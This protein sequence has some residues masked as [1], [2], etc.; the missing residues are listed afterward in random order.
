MMVGV[1]KLKPPAYAVLAEAARGAR[2]VLE[3]GGRVS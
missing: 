3:I 1:S 2:R